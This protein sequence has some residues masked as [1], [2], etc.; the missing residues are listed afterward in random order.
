EAYEQLHE[1]HGMTVDEIAAKVGKSRASVYARMKLLDLSPAARTAFYEGTLTPSTA[2]YVARIPAALQK[3]ALA[4]VGPSEYSK[5]PMS[6]RQAQE[7]IE[8][9]YMLRLA[10]APFSRKDAKLVEKAGACTTCPK[11]TG[12]QSELF[13]DVKSK[14]LCTDTLCYA[15][16]VDAEWAARVALAKDE[17]KEVMSKEEAKKLFPYGTT[18]GG[19]V[20]LDLEDE[21]YN[22]NGKSWRIVLDIKKKPMPITLVRDPK[23]GIHELV[24][25]KDAAARMPKPKEEPLSAAEKKDAVKY[26]K[27]EKTRASSRKARDAAIIA[28]AKKAETTEPPLEFWRRVLDFE[29][30]LTG[31]TKTL[32][33]R[34]FDPEGPDD[35]IIG[36][37]EKLSFFELRGLI[38]EFFVDGDPKLLE[39][40]AKAYGVKVPE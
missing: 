27:E 15:S 6:A 30:G 33:R 7:V 24:K 12:N 39:V 40:A 22:N 14:D 19:S 20:W 18:V 9:K 23:G 3:E 8:R 36:F 17:G 5:E 4:D 38:V 26:E 28:I 31:D 16:K 11:R 29:I 21:H 13:A 10:D 2:L 37:L 25:A 1:K 34:G 35:S 32:V